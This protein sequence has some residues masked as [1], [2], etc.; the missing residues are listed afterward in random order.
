[1]RIFALIMAGLVIVVGARLVMIALQ[2]AFTGKTLVRR[3]MRG[4]WQPAP[5]LEEAWKAAFRDGLMGILLI[6][7]GIVLIT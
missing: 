5:T 1:M 2:T 4:Q 3:G 6:V 7:L